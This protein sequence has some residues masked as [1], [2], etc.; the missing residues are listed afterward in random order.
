MT[1]L[2]NPADTRSPIPID[3]REHYDVGVIGAGP[4]GS[5]A[6]GRIAAAGWRVVLFEKS[7]YPGKDNVCGGMI[8]LKDAELFQIDPGI[9]EK[10]LFRSI[11]YYPWGSIEVSFPETGGNAALCVQRKIFDRYLADRAVRSGAELRTRCRV[12]RVRRISTGRMVSH[13]VENDKEK[14]IE[15]RMV[16]FADGPITLAHR[17][18]GIGLEGKPHQFAVSV[19]CDF[20]CPDNPMDYFE[21]YY[22]PEIAKWGFGWLFPFSQHLNLGLC[23]LRSEVGKNRGLLLD[24]LNFMLHNYPPSSQLVERRAVILRRGALIPMDLARRIHDDSCLVVGDAAGFVAAFT[25]V[26]ITYALHSGAAAA[27]VAIEALRSGDFSAAFLAQ[28]P[29]RWCSS[30]KFK[31]LRLMNLLKRVLLVIHR[32]DP[33]FTNKIKFIF[34]IFFSYPKDQHVRVAEIIRIVFYPLLGNPKVKAIRRVDPHKGTS[35]VAIGKGS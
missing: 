6:A 23:F 24:R 31:R 33:Q 13:V 12:N 25:G 16:V 35:K 20:E 10:K 32:I 27:E 9:I 34:N 28:Y 4:A 29:R 17:C 3:Q 22:V 8:G 11:T 18:F 14:E 15:T 26:G 2:N 5:I 21:C 1:T 19:I 30:K 7:E